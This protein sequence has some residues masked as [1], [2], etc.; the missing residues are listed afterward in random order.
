MCAQTI[1]SNEAGIKA[2][3]SNLYYKDSK[4]INNIWLLFFGIQT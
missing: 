3:E 1:Q 4:I 2:L